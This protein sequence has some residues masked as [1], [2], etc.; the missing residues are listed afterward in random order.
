MCEAARVFLLRFDLRAPSFGADPASLYATALEMAAFSETRGGVCALVSEHHSMADGYLPAPLLVASAIAART[1]IIPILTSALVLPL[2]D[3]IRLAED[4]IVLDILSRGRAS[5]ILAVGYRPEEFAHFGVDFHQRGRIADAHL[6]VLLQAKTGEAFVHDGRHLQVTPA[7]FTP[8]GPVVHIGGGSAAA[9]RRAARHGLDFYAQGGG[10][11][12]KDLYRNECRAN[13]HE[14]GFCLMPPPDLPTTVF[15]A[16]DVDAAWEELGPHL[17]HDVH[18]YAA[19]NPAADQT[20]SMSTATTI[21]DLRAEQASHRILTVDDAVA[22]IRAGNIL[23]LHPL[24]GG[25][26]P[27]VA[28]RYL[29]T[30]TDEVMGRLEAT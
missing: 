22:F 15:V 5:H 20:A 9:A 10:R 17:L 7:P 16:D 2:Y 28:W 13:G 25:L 30:V 19:V 26:D 6:D 3:P 24:I 18:S 23:Q 29:R 11:A 8:G 12:L 14:P 27:A 1:E 4:L 21:D